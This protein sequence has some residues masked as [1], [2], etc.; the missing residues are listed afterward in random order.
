M[1]CNLHKVKILWYNVQIAI[2][3]AWRVFCKQQC[4]KEA[5]MKAK[6]YTELYIRSEVQA[7]IFQCDGHFWHGGLADRFKGIVTVFEWCNSKNILFKINFID[8]FRLYDYIEPNGYNWFV[9]EKDVLYNQSTQPKV[10]MME[11]RTCHKREIREKGALLFSEW[12]DKNLY[13]V[14]NQI[15]IYTNIFYDGV[16]F[17]KAFNILFK[18][19]AK[20]QQQIDYH[21]EKIGGKYISISYRFTTLLGDFKDCTTTVLSIEERNEL[22]NK[23]LNIVAEIRKQAPVH[24]RVLV[25]A[26]SPTFIER[27]KQLPD[28]YVIPGKIG[29]IDYQHDDDVNMKT[30]LDFFLISKAE[31]VYLAKSGQ[32]YRSTFAK[33]AAMVN[34]KPF[35]MYEF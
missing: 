11:P 6:Y 15:H 2:W 33:T 25:T 30:F 24:K 20:L 31:K 26:D 9:A 5:Y 17:S 13:I 7:V 28:V 10:C 16:N 8:P 19:T 32:M 1:R 14:D 4:S 12:L 22:I 27:V 23:C 21:L 34:D 35:E 3:G 29:H 18:P